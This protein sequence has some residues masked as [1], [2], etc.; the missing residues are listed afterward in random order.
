M[1]I[2]RLEED[3][4]DNRVSNMLRRLQ[5]HSNVTFRFSGPSGRC[6]LFGWLRP[7]AGGVKDAMILQHV[8]KQLGMQLDKGQA[9]YFRRARV[10]SGIRARMWGRGKYM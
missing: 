8:S 10:K 7:F 3:S 2:M 5:S 4:K 6:T 1:E 9:F